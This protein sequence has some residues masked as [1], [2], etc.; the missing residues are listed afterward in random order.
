MSYIKYIILSSYVLRG[1]FLTAFASKIRKNKT[2]FRSCAFLNLSECHKKQ[3]LFTL[4]YFVKVVILTVFYF[5]NYVSWL[6]T[7]K[8]LSY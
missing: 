6:K 4:F 1:T 7:P 5:R 2:S 8:S 3:T